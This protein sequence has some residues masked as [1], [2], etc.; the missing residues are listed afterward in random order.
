MLNLN[1]RVG[2]TVFGRA[3]RAVLDKQVRAIG[4][5]RVKRVELENIFWPTVFGEL[6]GA[7]H[8]ELENPIRA[9][10]CWRAKRVELTTFRFVPMFFSE[11]QLWDF[12]L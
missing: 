11:I 12:F 9:N 4:F 7:K 6:L 3:K 10:H 2:S 5:G 8:V 1:T